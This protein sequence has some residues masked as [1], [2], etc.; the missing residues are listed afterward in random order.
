MVAFS[1]LVILDPPSDNWTRT[2]YVNNER[3][4]STGARWVESA[5]I[6]SDVKTRGKT[7]VTKGKK[8]TT[9][10]NRGYSGR[11]YY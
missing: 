6:V 1:G 11:R 2:I 9:R 7:T 10:I 8:S 5:N 3:R 4:E